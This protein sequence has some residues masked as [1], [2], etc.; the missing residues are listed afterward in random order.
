MS[1]RKSSCKSLDVGKHGGFGDS[2]VLLFSS[3]VRGI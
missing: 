2:Q 1:R 3:P